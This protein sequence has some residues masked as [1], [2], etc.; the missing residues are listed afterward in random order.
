MVTA[1]RMGLAVEFDGEA[2]EKATDNNRKYVL[3]GG[4]VLAAFASLCCAGVVAMVFITS[5]GLF[6]DE[7]VASCEAFCEQQVECGATHRTVD[8][9]TKDCIRSAV[10]RD[11]DCESEGIAFNNCIA[12]LTC[13]EYH[14]DKGCRAESTA[15]LGCVLDRQ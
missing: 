14:N 6:G 4:G 2:E 8:A 9:C 3:I 11:G 1:G 7:V 13:F 5:S 15:F 12:G 10:R